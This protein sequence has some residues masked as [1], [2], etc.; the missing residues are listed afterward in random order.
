MNVQNV[1]YSKAVSSF[2]ADLTF[3]LVLDGYF[4]CYETS[5]DYVL[6]L[7]DEI[8]LTIHIKHKR[9]APPYFL[10]YGEEMLYITCK[11]N[12]TSWYVF[13]TFEEGTYYIHHITN[14][15]V[16]GHHF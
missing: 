15:H 5:R 3:I 12:R 11:R 16:D 1:R 14:N 8:E 10:R 9:P 2:L 6:K 4:Y 13:F 7:M